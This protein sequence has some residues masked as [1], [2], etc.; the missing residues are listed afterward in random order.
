MVQRQGEYLT[1]FENSLGIFI[2]HPTVPG[3]PKAKFPGVVLFS[4]IYQG[5]AFS[6]SA[7]GIRDFARIM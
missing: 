4:E 1:V 7:A 6:S 3:Y 5:T 2:F